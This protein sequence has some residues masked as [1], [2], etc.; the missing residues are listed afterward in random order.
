MARPAEAGRGRAYCRVP[1]IGIGP[2][3]ELAWPVIVAPS[4]S[5]VYGL[6]LHEGQEIAPKTAEQTGWVLHGWSAEKGFASIFMGL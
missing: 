3:S 5:W 6:A 1:V 4:T 2:K